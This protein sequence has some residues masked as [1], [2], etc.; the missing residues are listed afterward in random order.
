MAAH[1]L[2]VAKATF[3]ASLLRPDVTQLGREEAARFHV[4]F[5]DTI[6]RGSRTNIQVCLQ[7]A[8]TCMT[9][10]GAY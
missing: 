5:E 9:R 1:N 2:T 3:A 8:S 4:L 7:D 6:R 10:I